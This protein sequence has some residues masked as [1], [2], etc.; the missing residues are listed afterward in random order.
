MIRAVQASVLH[1]TS[2]DEQH[3]LCS[4]GDTSWCNFRSHK[5]L[6]LKCHCKKCIPEVIVKL[7]RPTYRK[8]GDCDILGRCVGGY[9]QNTNEPLYSLHWKFCLEHLLMEKSAVRLYTWSSPL[10]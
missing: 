1:K 3:N 5:A 9:T 6:G 10:Q 8:L 7:L 2:T 4:E